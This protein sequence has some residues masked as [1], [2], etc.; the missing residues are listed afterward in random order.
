MIRCDVDHGVFFGEW[1]SPPDPSIAMPV[2]GAPLVLYVPLHVDDGLAITNSLVLYRWFLTTLS[3]RLLIVDLGECSKFLSIL[4]ILDRHTRRLWL[5][6]HLYV[7]ELLEKWNLLTC[8]PVTSLFLNK[9]TVLPPA[10]LNSLCYH[11]LLLT[12]SNIYS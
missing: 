7:S 9:L 5:S 3:A 11:F 8:K 1:T 2:D 4:I 10:P 12:M 6:S